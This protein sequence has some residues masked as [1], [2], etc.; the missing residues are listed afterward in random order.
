ML[1]NPDC[2]CCFCCCNIMCSM[3]VYYLLWTD[4]QKLCSWT[5]MCRRTTEIDLP[6][7]LNPWKVGRDG[8]V[9][10]IRK[11][12]SCLCCCSWM[13]WSWCD[14]HPTVA[15]KQWSSQLQERSVYV[16]ASQWL[17]LSVMYG[18]W[19]SGSSGLLLLLLLKIFIF[20][21]K[22]WEIFL[23]QLSIHRTNFLGKFCKIFCQKI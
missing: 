21:Q 7:L 18:L 22:I 1:T 3:G 15:W 13:W 19:T 6:F 10:L 2:F 20:W 8:S 14:C 12:K 16:C 23:F 11:D 9:M 5:C 4:L 17:I